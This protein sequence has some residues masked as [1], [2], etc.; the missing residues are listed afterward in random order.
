MID[1][2]LSLQLR[3]I[4]G[5]KR[6][7]IQKPTLN[8]LQDLHWSDIFFAGLVIVI[9]QACNSRS[10]VQLSCPMPTGWRSSSESFYPEVFY[11]RI[12][13]RNGKFV[14]NFQPISN[15]ELFN[16]LRNLSNLIKKDDS[17]GAFLFFTSEKDVDCAKF[18]NAAAQLSNAYDCAKL[19]LCIWAYGLGAK[20]KPKG[21]I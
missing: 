11:N 2:N 4:D 14:A 19:K 10:N 13:Y 17:Y 21:A 16:Q 9:L 6:K 5:T 12:E 15:E 7:C 20:A 3:P 1:A 18:Q 8:L